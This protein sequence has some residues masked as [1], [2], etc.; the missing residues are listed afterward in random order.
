MTTTSPG[1][2]AVPLETTP[3]TQEEFVSR[4]QRQGSVYH[5]LHPFH[6][7]MN[8]G[9]L[10]PEELRRWVTNRY[11]YQRSIPL[12][13][14]AILANCEERA[15]RRA[16]ITRILDHDGYG[17]DEGGI[18]SWLRLGESL[19]V[20]REEMLDERHVLPG[21]A[22]ACDAYVEFCRR[23]PWIIAVASSLTELF[24]PAAIKVRI[25]A[26]ERH[27]QWIDPSG[28][29]Y[30]R[31]RLTRAP[32]DASEALDLVLAR[33]TRRDQQEAAVAALSFKCDMLWAQLDAIDR[34]VTAPEL[35]ETR[36]AGP[37]SGDDA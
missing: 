9:E 28:L 29:D 36:P 16:W 33:C 25:D 24:G 7:R 1:N 21:V 14:A 31:D 20:P 15:V 3:W 27:Y 22:Y 12:K 34:G 13:D 32:R 8:A 35:G 23:Q 2:R 19:G 37:S 26:M 5:D 4:L 6:V 17:D 10:T 11:R 18:E 30:F